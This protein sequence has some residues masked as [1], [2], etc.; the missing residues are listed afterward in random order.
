MSNTLIS[1][2]SLLLVSISVG[3]QVRQPAGKINV[4]TAPGGIVGE[5]K[6]KPLPTMG[7][8]YLFKN[9]ETGS[10]RLKSGQTLDNVMFKYDLSRNRFET[11]N[12][13][14]SI[15]LNASSVYSFQLKTHDQGSVQYVNSDGYLLD[16]LPLS[17]FYKILLE[18]NDAGMGLFSKIDLKL[19]KSY[20][21]PA[22]DVGEKADSYT[23]VESIYLVSGINV[24][25]VPKKDFAFWEFLKENSAIKAWAKNEKLKW[26]RKED[27]IKILHHYN[28]IVSNQ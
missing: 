18:P 2:V 20:Y 22:L 19:K 13:Q 8:Q 16:Q 10:L 12:D 9:W 23:K 4:N 17:G 21:V 7:S 25:Q 5:I 27:L 26:K 6:E 1:C 15:T 28:S 14:K 11:L 24:Y 3:A